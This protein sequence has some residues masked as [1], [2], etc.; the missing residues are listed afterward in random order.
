[1]RR[2]IA[3]TM[4]PRLTTIPGLVPDDLTVLDA[5]IPNQSS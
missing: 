1:L 4:V 3:R 5:E 2:S